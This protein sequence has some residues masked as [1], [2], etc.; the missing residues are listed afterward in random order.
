MTRPLMN[1][2]VDDRAN[3]S[4][5]IYTIYS[6]LMFLDFFSSFVFYNIFITYNI[7]LENIFKKMGSTEIVVSSVRPSVRLLFLSR[8]ST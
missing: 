8:Y 7:L 1:Q 5:I 4:R 6:A 2:F 3:V